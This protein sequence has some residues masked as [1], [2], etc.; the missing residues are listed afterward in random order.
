MTDKELQRLSRGELLQ[1]L[2]T[3]T[4]ENKVLQE[5]LQKAEEEVRER[6]ITIENAGSL[7]E[8]SLALNQVFQ[9]ADAAAKE[10]L[11]NIKRTNE[12]QEEYCRTIRSDAQKKADEIIEEAQTYSRK[13]HAEADAYWKQVADRAQALISDYDA[14]RAFAHSAGGNETE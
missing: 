9:A 2:I 14:L 5:R 4:E 8:A 13:A 11:D 3:Q 12:Q 10:Y 6:R 1:M 7:A